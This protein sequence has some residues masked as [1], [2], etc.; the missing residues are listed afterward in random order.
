MEEIE[1]AAVAARGEPAGIIKVTAPLPIGVNLLAPA[2][3][4]FRERYPKLSVDL[5]LG[6]RVTDLIEEGIDVAVRV[7]H[8]ADSRL[9]SRRLA[10]H[11][12][13]AF[14]SPAY[15]AGHGTPQHPE[16]LAAHECVN[17]RYQS[18]RQTL[19]R[20]FHVCE[21]VLEILPDAGIVVDIS[22][23]VAAILAAG[24][25]IGISPRT[26]LRLMSGVENWCRCL[27]NLCCATSSISPRS[28]RRVG[29]AVR[30]S[31]LLSSF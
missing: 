4:R 21:R 11:R 30:T 3:P 18:S 1:Q 17:F 5:R 31:K 24:D 19:R 22:D 7:G 13:C 12:L 25:G 6:D 14:A 27:R 28:G 29:G 10:P 16:D 20:P 15:L 26:S 23:A 8:V 2:L 9:I